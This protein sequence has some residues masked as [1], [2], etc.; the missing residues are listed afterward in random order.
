MFVGLLSATK[1]WEDSKLVTEEHFRWS[2]F[3]PEDDV[4]EMGLPEEY[5]AWF[6]KR[7]TETGQ[8]CLALVWD[9][10]AVSPEQY[11]A[12]VEILGNI[13]RQVGGVGLERVRSQSFGVPVGEEVTS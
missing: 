13:A 9:P 6:D 4:F 11:A 2:L 10:E 3:K 1:G 5:Q 7:R 12:V 8:A